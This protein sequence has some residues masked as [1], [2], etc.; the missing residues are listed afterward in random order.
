MNNVEADFQQE[1]RTFTALT[2][3]KAAEGMTLSERI[4]IYR[5]VTALLP[6]DSAARSAAVSAC[7][8]LEQADRNQLRLFELL[9]NQ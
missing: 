4:M 1:C 6:D 2:A 9:D 5:G 3:L 8:G 7:V